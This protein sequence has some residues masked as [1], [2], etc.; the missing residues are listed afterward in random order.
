MKKTLFTLLALSALTLACSPP[1]SNGGGGGGGGGNA[2]AGQ[3]A[4]TGVVAD[5]G[6]VADTG[7]AAD[8]GPIP[9]DNKCTNATDMAAVQAT[10]ENDQTAGDIAKAC[11]LS[12]FQQQG[13][14]ITNACVVDCMRTAT[15]G[16][17]SD[18]CLG[19]FGGSVLCTA[20]NCALLCAADPNSAGCLACQCGGNASG[21]N[22]YDQY[23]ACS[24]IPSTVDCP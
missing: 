12:C 9:S 10:Y 24:G 2:D 11:G 8:T 17:I 3:A 21:T 1:P 7:P 18:D 19:C 13:V 16:D 23:T 4:D 5:A 14:A 22:C 15:N 6:S 20:Q